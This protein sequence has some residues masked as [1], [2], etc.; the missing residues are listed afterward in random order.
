MST[1][2]PATGRPATPYRPYSIALSFDAEVA[3]RQH[4]AWLAVVDV[5]TI[6]PAMRVPAAVLIDVVTD[7]GLAERTAQNL[8]VRARRLGWISTNRRR[9]WADRTVRLTTAGHDRWAGQV[10]TTERNPS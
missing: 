6:R 1:T 10:A 3:P 4:A 8:L 7:T 5:L 2:A 9:L